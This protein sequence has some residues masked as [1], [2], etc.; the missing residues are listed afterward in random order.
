M[1]QGRLLRLIILISLAHALVH[2]YE[3]STPSI[4]QNVA[5]EYFPE[6]PPAGKQATGWMAWFW[7]FPW[8]LGALVAGW[9][10]DRLG[11]RRMLAAYLI[12]CGACCLLLWYAKSLPQIYSLMFVMGAFAS[13]YHPAGLAL[14]SHET[15]SRSLPNALGIHGVLGSAGIASAPFI[16]AFALAQDVSW[17]GFYVLLA[18]PGLLLGAFFLAYARRDGEDLVR[19]QTPSAAENAAQEH[20][21]WPSYFLLTVLAMTQGLVYSAVL[22][23]LP[24]YLDS[25]D[26]LWRTEAVS[27]SRLATSLILLIGCVGQY[28]AGRFADSRRLEIQLTWITL[29]NAPCLLAMA[30]AKGEWRVAAA[31]AFALVHFMHQPIYNSLISKYSPRRRRSLCYGFSFAMGLGIGGTGS[32]LAG[33]LYDPLWAH[34]LL[35]GAAVGAA[36]MAWVLHLRQGGSENGIADAEPPNDEP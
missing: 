2:M 14:I 32:V 6:D 27:V 4:E 5:A 3:Q 24:R 8:G 30:F 1:I 34:G 33:Y 13:I 20:A 9:M 23:F 22:T 35:A 31:G 29:A 25:L 11:S 21:D 19:R 12:G 10:V 28:L 26:S 18:L 16:A 36:G 17:R 7:R 15:D